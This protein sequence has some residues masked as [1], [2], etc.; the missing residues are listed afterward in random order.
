M[1]LQTM[2]KGVEEV[3]ED[4]MDLRVRRHLVFTEKYLGT[5]CHGHPTTCIFISLFSLVETLVSV[6][7]SLP[8][9]G[10]FLRSTVFTT[11]LFTTDVELRRPS[12]TDVMFTVS[13]KI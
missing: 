10:C 13:V 2:R 6:K 5:C 9:K 8:R 3:R 12:I 11:N 4:T 7:G 1:F